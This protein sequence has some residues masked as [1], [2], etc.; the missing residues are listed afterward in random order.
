MIITRNWG[1][2][3]Q[4]F[5]RLGPRTGCAQTRCSTIDMIASAT[6]T[7]KFH[8]FTGLGGCVEPKPL[9]SG[10]SWPACLP[11]ELSRL[12][13]PSARV[14]SHVL[15]TTGNHNF[16][17]THLFKTGTGSGKTFQHAR[18]TGIVKFKRM[19]AISVGT[20]GDYRTI[21]SI[22]SMIT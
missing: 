8:L 6:I 21:M 22:M 11:P 9:I 17:S 10:R 5:A 13:R 12:S 4:L 3:W 15:A 16:H 7:Y 20:M 19:S 2:L 14:V 1:R 18:L